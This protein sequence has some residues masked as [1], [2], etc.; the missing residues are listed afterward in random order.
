MQLQLVD[1]YVLKRVCW[2]LAAAVLFAMAALL[3]ERLIRLLDLFANRG[4]PLN[5]ILKMLG[6]LVPHYLAI[7]IPAAFFV[8]VLYATMR[9]S[10]DSELDA[11]RASGVSLRRLSAP[12]FALAVIMMIVSVIL[13]GVLQPY[14]RYAYRALLHIVTETS[15]NSAIERGTFFT[16]FG[17]KTMLIGDIHKGGRELG[18]IF[19][20][21]YDDD[22]KNVVVTAPTGE[23]ASDPQ[24]F[25]LKLVLRN[26]VRLLSNLDGTSAQA[27]EFDELEMPLEVLEPEQFRS[28]G[29][30]ESELTVFELWRNYPNKSPELS[31]REIIGELN[32]RLVR[33]LSVLFLP[34]L[35]IPIGLSPRRSPR[36]IRLIIGIAMLVAYY[37]VIEFG[38]SMVEEGNASVILALWVPFLLFVVP[39]VWLFHLAHSKVGQDPLSPVLEPIDRLWA[40]TAEWLTER[41]R[42]R[43]AA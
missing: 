35:A 5:L 9:M 3:M 28:R 38:Q 12:I 32:Y 16:G 19:I 40:S 17:G 30:K 31:K 21:E 20:Q 4:G 22:G 27:L 7:A 43:R 13:V 26:G 14:T 8:G 11:F 36:S 23:L 1:R 10:T 25:T 42:K 15:W 6:Y 29:G 2:P 34:F 41:V 37:E 24:K 18:Q 39:S 33:T